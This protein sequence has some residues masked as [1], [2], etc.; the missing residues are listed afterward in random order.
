MYS[1]FNVYLKLIEFLIKNVVIFGRKIY[2]EEFFFWFLKYLL[3]E[4]ICI[5][6][7]I[8]EFFVVNGFVKFLNIG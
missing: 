7:G 2:I 5:V 8:F 4:F 6:L 3:I 1:F